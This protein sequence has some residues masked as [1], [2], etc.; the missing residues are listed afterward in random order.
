MNSFDKRVLIVEDNPRN[1]Q[2]LGPILRDAGYKVSVAVNGLKGLKSV[3]CNRPDIIL[4]DINMP[5][6]DGFEFCEKIM[7]NPHTSDI[8]IIFLTASDSVDDETKGL[9]LGAVDFIRKPINPAVV[10]ART[11]THLTLV[12]ALNEQKK[13]IEILKENGQLREQVEQMSRHDLKSPLQAVLTVPELIM[14]D[15]NLTEKQ[16]SYLSLLKE[17]GGAMLDMIN[18]SLDL[19]KMEMNTYIFQPE[20][21]LLN[22]VLEKNMFTLTQIA[23]SKECTLQNNMPD[24]LY[25]S[26]EFLLLY[27]LFGNLIKNAIEA[28]PIGGEIHIIAHAS[29]RSVEVSIT[30]LG[31]VPI[32]IR[33][34]FFD[35]FS[36]SGKTNGTGLGTYSAKLIMDTVNGE[37]VLD[38]AVSGKTTIR[39]LFQPYTAN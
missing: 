18:R 21:V 32:E 3:E 25:V 7:S 12:D 16:I 1:I 36:T 39:L 13:N 10:L 33:D 14:L 34:R 8:P 29:K 20:K 35:K 22:E 5:V 19:Y 11:Q 38:T 15:D 2:V 30:N 31:E 9:E 26:A 23:T 17:A 28:S 37:I 27:N 6:M 4:S 24:N